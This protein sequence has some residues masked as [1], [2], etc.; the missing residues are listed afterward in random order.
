MPAWEADIK[1]GPRQLDALREM[2]ADFDNIRAAWVWAVE[3]GQFERIDRSLEALTWFCKIN[4][5]GLNGVQLFVLAENRLDPSEDRYR[6]PAWRRIAARQLLLDE[7]FTS[8]S[9]I[10]MKR[11]SERLY[12][13]ALAQEDNPLEMAIILSIYATY[14]PRKIPAWGEDSWRF[15]EKAWGLFRQAGDQYWENYM[16][17]GISFMY[18]NKEGHS[19][20]AE[21]LHIQLDVARKNHDRLTAADAQGAL[22]FIAEM[23]GDYENAEAAYRQVLPVFQEFGDGHHTLEY[24]FRLAEIAI[25]KGDFQEARSWAERGMELISRVPNVVV[26]ST[27]FLFI[28]AMGMV[29]NAEERY[30]EALALFDEFGHDGWPQV[31]R[32]M[33]YTQCGLGNFSAARSMLGKENIYFFAYK[34]AG[35]QAFIL[36][37]FAL[38]SASEDDLELA[39]ELLSLSFHHPAAATGWLEKFP[40]IVRLRERLEK[41]LEPQALA[42]AWERGK[43][44]DLGETIEELLEDE[45]AGG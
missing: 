42:K 29:L 20:R 43:T 35:F 40:L 11:E 23:R 6:N 9:N 8:R 19:K 30:Q 38:I 3:N 45:G 14:L 25:I 32:V 36:P 5:R 41:E 44:L 31:I 12:Q 13:A 39:A 2:E 28:F 21:L 15:L 10:E 26:K 7:W 37:V 22:G 34:E 1:G 33:A 16:I 17:G 4:G 24:H 27:H 18:L